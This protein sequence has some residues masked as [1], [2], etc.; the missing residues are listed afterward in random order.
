VGKFVRGL[1]RRIKSGFPGAVAPSP[2]RAFDRDWY[3]KQNPDVTERGVDPVEHYRR[4]GRD[5]GRTPGPQL[6]SSP[7]IEADWRFLADAAAGPVAK[8]RPDSGEAAVRSAETPR[9]ATLRDNASRLNIVIVNHGSYDNNSAIHINGFANALI[10]L[11]HRVVVSATGAVTDAGDFGVPRFRAV[12]HQILR[13]W[14]QSVADYFSGAG[15][16]GPDLVHCWT[17]RQNV[18]ETA[19]GM[20][21]HYQCPYIVHFEDNEAAVVRAYESDSRRRGGP[22]PAKI[23]AAQEFVRGASAATI[24]VDALKE[25]MPAGLPHHLLE[26]G[27]DGDVF[28]PGLY[29]AERE[30]LCSALAVPAD[31]RITVYPGNIHPANYEDMFSLYAAIHALNERGH[32]VHLIRTGIDSVGAIDSRFVELSGRY[33]TNLGFVRRQWLVELFKLA[34]FFVQP[35]GPDDFNRYRLPS[36]I[37]ELLAMGKPVVL[38]KTNIGLL[39]QD[40]GNALLMERGDAPEIADCVEALLADPDLARRVGQ[41]GRRF[42]VEHFSWGR[43]ALGLEAF[44]RRVLN[45]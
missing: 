22:P 21:E 9:S 38:P 4:Y 23:A 39:M 41:G 43:S 26:P 17:P 19:R 27:V 33:V 18:Y 34:D 24:I 5:E 29:S 44:Y 3:V 42:A 8:S 15:T 12:P 20:I 13:E 30:R 35:G 10:G 45:R 31:A 14:P 32:K 16:G 7:R 28:A 37:P 1:L 25:I 36:K 40:R 11:G 6:L 2:P